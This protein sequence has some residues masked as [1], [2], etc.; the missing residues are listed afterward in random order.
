LSKYSRI[1][2]GHHDTAGASRH[3]VRSLETDAVRLEVVVVCRFNRGLD[4]LGLA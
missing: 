4:G 1:T 3:A 2:S